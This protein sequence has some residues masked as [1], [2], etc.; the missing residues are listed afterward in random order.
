MVGCTPARDAR[1]QILILTALSMTVLLGMAALSV[2]ASFMYDK[3]NRLYAAAD[4]AAKLAATEVHRRAAT[5]DEPATLQ[6]FANEE[7]ARHGFNPSG[8]TSV[9]M[10]CPPSSGPYAGNHTYVEALVSETT[11]TFFGNV[12][13][14]LSATP[15]ARAVAGMGP[16]ANCIVTLGGSPSLSIGSSSTISMACNVAAGGDITVDSSGSITGGSTDASGTC[17]GTG[18]GCS[19]VANLTIN[20]PAPTDPLAGLF[21]VLAN[22]GTCQSLLLTA[23][24]TIGPGC[25]SRIRMDATGITLT[26]TAGNYYINGPFTTANNPTIIGTGVF[27]YLDGT[28]PTGP[29][30]DS[31]LSPAG[32]FDIGNSATVTLS[33][34]TS[35]T[36]TAMLIWQAS[37]DQLNASF[38]GNNPTYD[39]SG[40]MYFPNADVTFR[41]GLSGTNDCTLFVTRS[42]SIDHGTG[43][44][45][46]TC[47]AYGGSPILAVSVAE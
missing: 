7:V 3:R 38:M 32:C 41:N 15:G 37:T 47:S 13:G 42:L 24:T 19:N 22:P 44:F 45:S 14:I 17:S 29:C 23:D 26:M 6:A 40:A 43:S 11:N 1:G 30:S 39:M 20:A 25:Y 5:C 9:V 8:A 21:P 2:D 31:P 10:N 16:G 12:L 33:A 36:Y 4:A 28:A 46:N 18:G 34:P 35:G 27:L